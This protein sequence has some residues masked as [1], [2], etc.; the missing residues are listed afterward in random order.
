M[1]NAHATG[2]SKMRYVYVL[3]EHT[4]L[5]RQI[6]GVAETL[7]LAKEVQDYVRGKTGN[8]VE[9][10]REQFIEVYSATQEQA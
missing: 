6:I 3:R 2:E 1:T 8:R 9:A 5:G 10:L 7:E 4:P